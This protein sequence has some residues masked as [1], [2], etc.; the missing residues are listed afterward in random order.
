[1]LIADTALILI[2]ADDDDSPSDPNRR[3]DPGDIGETDLGCEWAE[4]PR[5]RQRQHIGELHLDSQVVDADNLLENIA[6]R[7][8]KVSVRCIVLFSFAF[9]LLVLTFT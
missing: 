1:M 3:A 4:G 9:L 2:L 7:W 6:D 5:Y 8:E